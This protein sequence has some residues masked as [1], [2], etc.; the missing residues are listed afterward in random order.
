[1]CSIM[2]TDIAQLAT[3]ELINYLRSYLRLNSL[4]NLTDL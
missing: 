1:M 3:Y 2:F 4:I